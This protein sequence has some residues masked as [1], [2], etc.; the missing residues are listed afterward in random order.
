MLTVTL[1]AMTALTGFWGGGQVRDGPGLA[2]LNEPCQA[3]QDT[4]PLSLSRAQRTQSWPFEIFIG[5][6]NF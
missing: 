3:I 1:T 2:E 4:F 5:H 6:K